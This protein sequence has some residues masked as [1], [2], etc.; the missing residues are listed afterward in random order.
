MITHHDALVYCMVLL[1]AA[2]NDM[3]DNELRI[4]GD[5]VHSLPVFADYDTDRLT[6]TASHC[7]DLLVDEDGL[8]K[9]LDIV[10]AALPEKLRET[11]YALALD[12]AAADGEVHQ[13]EMRMLELI[14]HRLDI[15]RLIAAALERGV[16]AHFATA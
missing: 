12:V 14:R 13:E 11:A 15:D 3:T 16:R 6:E 9:A 10:V 5:I 7:A 8:D 4:I 1:S 2:D